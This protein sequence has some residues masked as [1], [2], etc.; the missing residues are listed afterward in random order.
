VPYT[1][2]AGKT[3]VSFAAALVALMALF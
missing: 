3:G 1:G 2:T